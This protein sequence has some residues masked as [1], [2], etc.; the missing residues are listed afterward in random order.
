MEVIWKAVAVM[1]NH[2]FTAAITY[3]EFL[4]SFR[5]CL[6]TGTSTL[7]VKLIQQVAALRE[8][9]LHALFLDLHNADDA[10]DS[11]RCLDILERYGV[12]TMSLLLLHI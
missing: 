8:A 9:V 3:H 2:R 10:L 7:E 12:G 5:A 6:S 4:H 11:S 1:L